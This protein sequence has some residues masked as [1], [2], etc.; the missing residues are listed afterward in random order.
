[1]I[2]TLFNNPAIVGGIAGG[3]ATVVIFAILFI[4]RARILKGSRFGIN[5]SNTAC[6]NCG[7][8]LPRIR[9]PKN[10]N[11]LLWGGWTCARCNNEYDKWLNPLTTNE[12]LAH[13]KT[14]PNQ[15]KANKSEQ[16]T[17][18]KLSD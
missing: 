17:P 18:R 10:M 7:T 6:P 14:N 9:T 5:F 4:T 15:K 1:M 13:N 12:N 16:T 11:Q 2:A 3:I 8:D